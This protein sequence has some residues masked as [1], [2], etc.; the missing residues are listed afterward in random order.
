MVQKTAVKYPVEA[1]CRAV[2]VSRSGYYAWA[3]RRADGKPEMEV[4]LAATVEAVFWRHARRYGARVRRG[5]A[6]RASELQ[7]VGHR[8][9][10]VRSGEGDRPGV[11]A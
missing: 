7:R 2:R 1:V 5:I 4:R 10:R 11:G 9:R 3:G 6:L 8:D